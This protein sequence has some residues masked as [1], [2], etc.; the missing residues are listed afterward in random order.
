MGRFAAYL[1]STGDWTEI[2][3]A[4]D[5]IDTPGKPWLHVSIHDSDLAVLR[6]GPSGTGTGTAYM[7][8]TPRDYFQDLDASAPTDTSVESAG[9]AEWARAA[10]TGAPDPQQIEELLAADGAAQPDWDDPDLPDEE[11]FVETKCA[12]LAMILGLPNLPW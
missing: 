1:Y 5:P 6:Y 10:H 3:P 7:G 11:V 2:D 12:K 4:I 8:S 9:L